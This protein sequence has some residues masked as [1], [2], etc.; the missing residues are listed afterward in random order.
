[1]NDVEAFYPAQEEKKSISPEK[2]K[3]RKSHTEED[4]KETIR[5]EC[6]YY[7]SSPSE[8]K[9]VSRYSTQRQKDYLEEKKFIEQ[10]QLSETV[11]SA[12]HALFSVLVDKLTQGESYV[13]KEMINDLTLR[14]AIDEEFSE[15]IC[16]LNNKI[17]IVFLSCVNIFNGKRK[18]ISER[19]AKPSIHISEEGSPAN[20][21]EETKTTEECDASLGDL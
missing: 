13:E 4:D 16:L 2:P 10:K 11:V 1:M 19:D 6:K 3:K 18:Q 20:N 8:W 15:L 14:H 17:R 9:L 7:C 12:T 21:C 5:K